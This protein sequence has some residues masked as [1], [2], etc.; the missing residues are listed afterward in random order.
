MRGISLNVVFDILA[1]VL[2]AAL[3]EPCL[4]SVL[5]LIDLKQPQQGTVSWIKALFVPMWAEMFYSVSV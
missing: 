2:Q 5:S 1:L 4:M 3:N